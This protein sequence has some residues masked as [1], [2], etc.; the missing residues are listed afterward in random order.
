MN[1]L[2]INQKGQKMKNIKYNKLT[3]MEKMQ[4]LEKL[5]AENCYNRNYEDTVIH[6]PGTGDVVQINDFEQIM[7]GIK[8]KEMPYKLL[9]NNG[10][11]QYVEFDTSFFIDL[12]EYYVHKLNVECK[13]IKTDPADGCNS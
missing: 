9:L 12:W 7:N 2:T 4:L 8:Y 5:Y 6:I 1:K 11:I 3:T 13:T 10:L